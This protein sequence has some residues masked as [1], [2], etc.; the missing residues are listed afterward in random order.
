ME[1]S[2]TPA[3]PL[4]QPAATLST[5]QRQTT[6]HAP[7]FGRMFFPRSDPGGLT[8]PLYPSIMQSHKETH[9]VFTDTQLWRLPP[10]AAGVCT[11]SPPPKT[12]TCLSGSGALNKLTNQKVGQRQ[13][14]KPAVVANICSLKR[15]THCAVFS[16]PWWKIHSFSSTFGP[17]V[18]LG[19]L[20]RAA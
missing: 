9:A 1:D 4:L 8:S 11:C 20:P 14:G 17:A 7:V 10:G 19:L 6:K 13:C 12:N 5:P 15:R 2:P 16:C 18:V 3:V